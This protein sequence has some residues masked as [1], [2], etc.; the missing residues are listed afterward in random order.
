M[1][2]MRWRAPL[3][4]VGAGFLI[5]GGGLLYGAI[6]VGVPTQDPT[7]EIASY[8]KGVERVSSWIMSTGIAIGLSGLLWA[9]ALRLAREPRHLR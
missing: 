4:V 8:E 1:A 2:A 3:V 6:G 5:F 7:P 9:G